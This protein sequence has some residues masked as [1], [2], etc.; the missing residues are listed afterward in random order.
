L[1]ATHGRAAGT[2]LA[3]LSL[4]LACAF[5]PAGAQAASRPLRTS[6][7]DPFLYQSPPVA[8][9][10]AS[11]MRDAGATWVRLDI[12]WD[13]VAPRVAQKPA[14]FDPSNPAD[15]AYDWSKPDAAVLEAVSKGLQPFINLSEAPPWAERPAGG[16]AGTNNPD[17]VEFRQFVAAAATRYS[18]RFAGLPR[19]RA[20]E[21]WNEPNASFFF[22]PQ[23]QGEPGK[24]ALSPVLYRRLVNEA[25]AAVHAVNPDNLVVAGST[26]PFSVNRPDVQAIGPMRFL[27]EL[28][29]LDGKLKAKPNCG[30]PVHFDVWSHHPYTSGSPTH[31]AANRDS[32]SIRDLPRMHRLLVAAARQGRIISNGPL[33]FWV[34]EFGW[35]SDPPDRGGVPTR[36][37]A[38]WVAEALYRMWKAK[39][40]LASW[41]LLR[42]GTGDD[43]RF[44]S[45][46]YALCP[47]NA[48]DV[49]CDRPKRSLRAFRFP[50]VAFRERRHTTIW[51]RTPR[52]VRGKVVVE[53]SAGRRWRRVA[54]LQTDADG[55]FERRLRDYRHG[56]LRARLAGGGSSSVPFSLRRPRDFPVSPPVG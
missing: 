52:G 6:I 16:R 30:E 20:W 7:Q 48:L 1:A 31:R 32:A 18:G 24:D 15:P 19:V 29:C 3:I 51:G 5:M 35:D 25:A 55:I 54:T 42:D 39:V 27:R 47:Q 38:R 33:D 23:W 44:Q 17:P 22:M 34:T 36:L 53:R 4:L 2:A 8:S 14:G 49:R 10:V 45:G 37:H 11:R 43:T 40:T 26:F 9:I 56:S 41:F 28:L 13:E 12:G 46:L 21:I 50:F